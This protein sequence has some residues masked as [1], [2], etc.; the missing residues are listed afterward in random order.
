MDKCG[1]CVYI[2]IP[3][4]FMFEI[5]S[6]PTK[7]VLLWHPQVLLEELLCHIIIKSFANKLLSMLLLHCI[8]NWVFCGS[9][10]PI[11]ISDNYWISKFATHISNFHWYLE[12]K[13][14]SKNLLTISI[15]CAI[16]KHYVDEFY[17][18]L[19]KFNKTDIM[20]TKDIVFTFISFSNY[21][22]FLSHKTNIT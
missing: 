1:S 21:D 18:T 22:M 15:T 6:K 7:L 10:S 5:D 13:S 2:I 14:I 20:P 3:I 9:C 17:N 12:K 19:F 8:S 16:I 11:N 4:S